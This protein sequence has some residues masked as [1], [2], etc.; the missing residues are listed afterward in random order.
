MQNVLFHYRRK[1][2]GDKINDNYI[3]PLNVISFFWSENEE[4]Q[5]RVLSVFLVNGF[6]VV[7]SENVGTKFVNHM[8]DFLRYMLGARMSAPEHTPRENQT[9]EKGKKRNLVAAEI[10]EEDEPAS[11]LPQETA[12][13]G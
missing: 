2:E 12:W 5:K 6:T 11:E 13:Q 1:V 3:N 8:E 9:R 10:I 7:F 4:T